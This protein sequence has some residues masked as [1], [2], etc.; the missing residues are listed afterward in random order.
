MFEFSSLTLPPASREAV[1][2]IESARKRVAFDRARRS[3]YYAGKLEHIDAERLD[4]PEEW[5]RI[6][7]LDK[8]ALRRIDPEAF[9]EQFCIAPATD[10]VEYWRSGGSTGRP[11]FYPRS[12][13]DM[14]VTREMWRRL[15]RATG[16]DARDT[17]HISFP[18]GIHPVGHLYAR[19]AEEL[20]IATVWAGAGGNTPSE[21]QV[22]LIR[23]LKPTVWCGMASYGLQLAALAERAGLDLANWSVRKLVCAA[24]PLSKAKREKLERLWNA[25]VF[26]Q[27]GCTEIGAM[28]SESECHDGLHV[29]TDLAYV[30]VVDE[31]SG[32]PLPPGEPGVLVFTPYYTNTITPFLRWNTGDIVTLVEHGATTGPMAVYPMFRHAQRTSGFF[33][34]RGVNINHSDFEDFMHRFAFVT[35]FRLEVAAG[36]TLD[37][38]RLQAELRK[39]VDR[40]RAAVELAQAVKQTFEVTPSVE[41]LEVGTLAQIFLSDVKAKRFVDS[42]AA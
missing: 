12:A 8:E 5:A 41:C 17:A 34:V 19:V 24:E 33:K 20:G 27:Y 42:R 15:W 13:L 25:E 9:H 40:T 7:I 16:C 26:D 23:T 38:L 10:A 28:G 36:A 35:D 29:W 3:R 14:Q 18:M 2:R 1:R 32:R 11:L 4:D 22:E 21:L 37:E 31:A 30:E 39:G 6:P